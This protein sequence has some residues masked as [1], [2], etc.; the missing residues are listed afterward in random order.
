M[1]GFSTNNLNG[2]HSPERLKEILRKLAAL[3][4]IY[5]KKQKAWLRKY[6][7]ARNADNTAEVAL[8]D[9]GAGD[10]MHIFFTPAGTLIHGFDHNSEVSPHA[11]DE[12]RV[13]EGMFD[14]I[15]QH[16]LRLLNSHEVEKEDVTFC[17]WCEGNEQKWKTG[18]VE[19]KNGE[20]D[21][22]AYL[23]S[24]IYDNAKDYKD[25]ADPMRKLSIQT[26]ILQ[27]FFETGM[28]NNGTILELNPMGN[29][30]EIKGE[31]AEIGF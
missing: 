4:I 2:F 8:V 7:F 15:P 10:R 31:L 9:N 26:D 22:S 20:D 29:L 5:I 11:R 12:Y 24:T 28:L 19:F 13:W 6:S 30:E 1:G 18:N 14:G 17:F 27:D 23:L 3:D 21:G 25:W 16:L